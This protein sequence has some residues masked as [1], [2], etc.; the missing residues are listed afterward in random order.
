VEEAFSVPQVNAVHTYAPLALLTR[1]VATSEAKSEAKWEIIDFRRV[2]LDLGDIFARLES[3][4]IELETTKKK[5]AYL[6]V[7]TDIEDEEQEDDI[8][9]LRKDV[10]NLKTKVGQ[11]PILTIQ[12]YAGRYRSHEKLETGDV[13]ASQGGNLLKA[14]REAAPIGVIAPRSEDLEADEYSVV[15][16]G[17]VLCRIRGRVQADDLLV[18]AWQPG[19]LERASLWVRWFAPHRIVARA[20]DNPTGPHDRFI[21][22]YFMPNF[23][24]EGD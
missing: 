13:V 12:R 21:N 17:P 15:L 6:H 3:L 1:Q 4:R 22:V 8:S 23:T 14:S 9:V 19:A 10:S 5:L 2:F 24:V 11:L 20:I 16:S 7:E 18:A